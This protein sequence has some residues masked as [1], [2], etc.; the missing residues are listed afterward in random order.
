MEGYTLKFF[1]VFAD[2]GKW[3]VKVEPKAPEDEEDDDDDDT[4]E[5]SFVMDNTNR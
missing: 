4:F 2:E 3:V 5:E 1:V